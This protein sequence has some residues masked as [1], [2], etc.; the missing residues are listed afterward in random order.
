MLPLYNLSCR[1][2]LSDSISYLR[3]VILHQLL[4]V[5]TASLRT[6]ASSHPRRSSVVALFKAKSGGWDELRWAPWSIQHGV[7]DELRFWWAPWTTEIYPVALLPSIFKLQVFKRLFISIIS[8]RF[9]MS[10]ITVLKLQAFV[11]FVTVI[12]IQEG[13][14]TTASGHL[15]L[16]PHK[17]ILL[18]RSPPM[19]ARFHVQ[20]R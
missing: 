14:C 6:H 9:V 8:T 18:L 17:L 3:L 10:K 15:N 20:V 12:K 13:L 4:L 1:V 16:P 11:F 7:R 2:S 5:S 19:L